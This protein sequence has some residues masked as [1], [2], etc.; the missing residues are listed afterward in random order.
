MEIRTNVAEPKIKD[1]YIYKFPCSDGVMKSININGGT[2]K[3]WFRHYCNLY[4]EEW[5]FLEYDTEMY[6]SI[7]SIISGFCT[8][9]GY[10][11]VSFSRFDNC[12]YTVFL[13]D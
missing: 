5:N 6:Y 7:S 2:L 11:L 13:K 3:E 9:Y 12:Y 10:S 1:Y 4:G 8:K